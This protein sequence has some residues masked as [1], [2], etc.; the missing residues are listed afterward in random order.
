LLQGVMRAARASR[1]QRGVAAAR[2][3]RFNIES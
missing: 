3:S 1:Q 2:R